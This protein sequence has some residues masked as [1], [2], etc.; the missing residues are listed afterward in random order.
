MHMHTRP[1]PSIPFSFFSFPALVALALALPA[2][3]AA[4]QDSALAAETYGRASGDTPLPELGLVLELVDGGT[5]DARL[6]LFGG[7]P[8]QPATILVSTTKVAAA[9]APNGAIAL[10]GPTSFRSNG[11]FDWRG[12]YELP[13]AGIELGAGESLY[14]QGIHTGILDFGGTGPL[15]QVSHGLELRGVG[16]ASEEA[17]GF[18]DFLPHL[19]EASDLAGTA[20]LTERLQRMLN[21][22]GDSVRLALEI[23]AS[24]GLGIEVVDAKVGGKVSVEFTLERGEDGLY[25]VQLGADV[26]ALAGVSA[27]TGAEV[28]LE[29]SGGSGAA[30]YFRFHSAPGAAR[31]ILGMVLALRFPELQPGRLLENSG[32][33]GDAAARVQD[34]QQLVAFAEEHAAELEA[35]LWEVLDAR[36]DVAEAARTSAAARLASANRNYANAPWYLRAVYWA[37]VVACRAVLA[38][39][40]ARLTV[41]RTARTQGELAVQAA[42]AV[43]QAKRAEFLAAAREVA[44]IGRIAASIAQLRGWASDHYA[45]SEVRFK[46]A[47]EVEAKLKAPVVDMKNFGLGTSR[48]IEQEFVT[49]WEPA[50]GDEPARVTVL[51]ALQV[52]TKAYAGLVLGGEY[53]SSRRFEIADTFELG[54]SAPAARTVSFTRDTSLVGAIGL[55]VAQEN[56]VGRTRSFSFAPEGSLDLASLTSSEA[57]G[58]YLGAA[59]VGLELQDRRQKNVDVAFAIDVSGTGGGIEIELEWADQGRRLARTTT[60]QEG[61]ERILDG[62]SEVIDVE[63]G[64]VLAFE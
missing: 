59:E 33:L 21:S 56:G 29:G 12:I 36:V 44:R 52:E 46:T 14:A 54:A 62:A 35:F 6:R 60:V 25:E 57:L 15:Q 8:G 39:A 43:I 17:L 53:A 61:L 27:G 26:A 34:L 41:V 1:D 50:H 51:Q 10:V 24:V 32:I 49:R 3:P 19:P 20:G 58:A 63:T 9:P 64:T 23:E 48:E 5:P 38:G 13:L 42:K 16:A 40:D 37:Q 47:G 7:L 4:G 2:G 11:T 55:I 45:G 18:D 30:R 31:G 22:A 28:G